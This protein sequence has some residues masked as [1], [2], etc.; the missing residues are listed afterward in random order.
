MTD[1]RLDPHWPWLSPDL[2]YVYIY[3]YIYIMDGKY[4]F[5]VL[6]VLFHLPGSIPQW[7]MIT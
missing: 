6:V 1:G 7:R 3:I 2:V 5:L 4:Q